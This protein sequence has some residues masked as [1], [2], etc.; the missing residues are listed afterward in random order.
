[1]NFSI[2]FNKIPDL[3]FL[4]IV[5]FVHE[6]N[7]LIWGMIAFMFIF[8]KFSF[9]INFSR[10]SHIKSSESVLISIAAITD[11]TLSK[12]LSSN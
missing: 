1:M 3:S 12:Y 4:S 2:V 9:L 10:F 8:F 11:E 5:S 7:S 6:Y